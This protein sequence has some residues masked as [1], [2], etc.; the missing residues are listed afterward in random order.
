VKQEP[1]VLQY[2]SR[3]ENFSFDI[4]LEMGI[5][6]AQMSDYQFITKTNYKHLYWDIAQQLAHHSVNGC[7][8]YVGDLLASG[9]ISG[10][11]V[12]SYGSLI[13]ITEGG[14]KE[15]TLNDGSKRVYLQ[16]ND[17]VLITGYCQG[18]GYRVGFGNLVSSIV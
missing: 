15:L 11:T 2:L 7:P 16:N 9:T 10:P 5:K 1:S 4:N 17:S 13:E 3:H 8:M 18:Q 12:G 6:T 14:K